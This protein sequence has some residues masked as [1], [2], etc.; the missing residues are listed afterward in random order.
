MFTERF[1]FRNGQFFKIFTS[2]L[3]IIFI[4]ALVSSLILYIFP[5]NNI[6]FTSV[7]GNNYEGINFLFFQQGKYDY[8]GQSLSLFEIFGFS[9]RRLHGIFWEPGVLGFFAN[10]YTYIQLFYYKNNKAAFFGSFIIILTWSSTAIFLLIFQ[11]IWGIRKG[12]IVTKSQHFKPFFYIIIL[13]TMALTTYL[14][15]Q[16]SQEKLYNNINSIAS[17][18]QRYY[19]TLGALKVISDNPISGIGID[20]A[21]VFKEINESFR[22]INIKSSLLPFDFNVIEKEEVKFSNSFLRLFVIF[23][24]PIAIYMLYLVY[25]QQ[26]FTIEKKLFFIIFCLTLSFTPLLFLPFCFTFIISGLKKNK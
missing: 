15:A 20:H 21:V 7:N 14:F 6:V 18:S 9:L 8:F 19:D 4:Y 17:A 22:S 25:N 26:V 2:Q 5:T 12:Y 16:N 24:V 11:F 23:G 1:K 3:N 10:L 13:L